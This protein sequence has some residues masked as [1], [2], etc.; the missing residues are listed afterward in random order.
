MN[1]VN[2]Y[3]AFFLQKLCNYYLLDIEDYCS[4]GKW[5]NIS[6]PSIMTES[7]IEHLVISKEAPITAVH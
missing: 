4:L 2:V 6:L 3:Q 7:S 5:Q 1:N